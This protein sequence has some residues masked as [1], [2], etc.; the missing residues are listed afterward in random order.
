MKQAVELVAP[1][2][3]LQKRIFACLADAIGH[4]E[5]GITTDIYNAGLTSIGAIRLNVLLSREFD[6]TV[7]TSDLKNNPTI[8]LLEQFVLQAGGA[9]EYE[10]REFQFYR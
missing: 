3:Q 6:I 8:L 10:I 5:F 9:K 7:R 1:E 2:T 4:Q